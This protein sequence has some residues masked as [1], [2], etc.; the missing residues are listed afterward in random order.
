MSGLLTYPR[1]F[2]FRA[3]ARLSAFAEV[4][5]PAFHSVLP[6]RHSAV[7]RARPGD[8]NMLAERE[9]RHGPPRFGAHLGTAGVIRGWHIDKRRSPRRRDR[10]AIYQTPVAPAL[11]ARPATSPIGDIT[12]A[13]KPA[14]ARRIR[15]LPYA[16]FRIS[17][18]SLS[19]F[20]VMWRRQRTACRSSEK[21]KARCVQTRP[22]RTVRSLATMR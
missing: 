19:M 20:T 10:E 4:R 14:C 18:H 7:V 1:G 16:H 5:P 17:P 12:M 13:A 22:M 9:I 11:P 6:G 15:S 2:V 8:G 3:L 21:E